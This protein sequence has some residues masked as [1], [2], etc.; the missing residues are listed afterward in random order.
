M[1]NTVFIHTNAQQMAGAIV[2]RHSLKRQSAR[3]D[4]IEVKIT[5]REDF[6]IFREYEGRKFLRAGGWRVWRNDDLQSFTPVRFS[7]PEQMGYAGRAVVIDPDVFAVGDIMELFDRDMG[8]KAIL[9][10]PRPG[11]NGRDDYIATSAMLLDCAKLTHWNMAR[12][13]ERMF[14][15]DLDY[16]NW[17]ILAE[18]TRETIGELETIWN[19]F[20][21]LGADT[22]L[23]HNT[24]RRTQPWKTGLPIDF[25]N[26]VPLIGRWLPGAGVRLPGRYKPHPDPRQEALFFS[27]LAECLDAGEVSEKDLRAEM[28][29]NHIRH[30]AL[31][32]VKSAPGVDAIL[33]QVGAAAA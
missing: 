14:S 32:R 21:R 12:N 26:R 15:G 31:E 10:R 19:D 5:R 20:D 24:K 28:S 27:Y 23:L 22:R 4:A 2:A 8:G 3:P 7:P 30:D 9:A 25:T 6:P 16:E 11:H 33:G 1:A 18:E 29:A 17:I 13:L